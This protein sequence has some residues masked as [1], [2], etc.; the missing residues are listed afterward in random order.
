MNQ[1]HAATCVNAAI[2]LINMSPTLLEPYV[3]NGNLSIHIG[4]ATGQV[5]CGVLGNDSIKR[6]SLIGKPSLLASTIERYACFSAIPMLCDVGMYNQIQDKFE[7]RV[8]LQP[9]IFENTVQLLYEI[10]TKETSCSAEWMYSSESVDQWEVF[11]KVATALLTDHP[12]P[13]TDMK[14]FTGT[15]FDNLRALI[16]SGPPEPLVISDKCGVP[17][18]F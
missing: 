16:K 4:M 13:S 11:N 12:I 1:R 14:P 5:F 17:A 8:H 2:S 15:S 6:Y 7:F 18:P 3:C 9:I 10:I